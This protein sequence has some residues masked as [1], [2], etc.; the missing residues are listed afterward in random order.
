MAA[1]TE[2]NR[3]Y[4]EAWEPVLNLLA[5]THKDG[6]QHTT[7]VGVKQSCKDAKET[8]VE[9]RRLNEEAQYEL[10]RL[11]NAIV[12]HIEHKGRGHASLQVLINAARFHGRTV[13]DLER[14]QKNGLAP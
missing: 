10:D 6:G 1:A 7:K 14:S 11:L 5:I 13:P 4:E 2:S 9:L 3:I 8:V 12:Q